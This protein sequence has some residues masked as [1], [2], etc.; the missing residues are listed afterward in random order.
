LLL[1]LA[2]G[3]NFLFIV[4]TRAFLVIV[5]GGLGLIAN[6]IVNQGSNCGLRTLRRLLTSRFLGGTFLTSYSEV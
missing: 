4:F 5:G 2:R 6:V 1:W 3:L